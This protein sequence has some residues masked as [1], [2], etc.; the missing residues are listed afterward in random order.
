MAKD[1]FQFGDDGDDDQG[2]ND[3]VSQLRRANKQQAKAL[4]ELTDK[5]DLAEVERG[6]LAEQVAA[7]TVAGLL[8]KKGLD[9]A[10][11]KFL[12]GVEP[13]TEAIDAWLTENGKLFGYD[14]SKGS[15]DAQGDE[16]A[17]A[18]ARA[19]QEEAAKLSPEMQAFQNALKGVQDQ[20][21][22]AAPG[23]VAGDPALEALRRLGQGAQSFEDVEK[24]LKE[25]GL[26]PASSNTQSQ[27]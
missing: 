22:N 8:E 19:A 2:G 5:Y 16:A 7:T 14:P 1:Q 10:V 6:K 18:A 9:P 27:F 23:T 3:L 24:G 15:G 21:A 25:M 13:T 12:K 4:K 11:S 17:Q 26:I 20:E